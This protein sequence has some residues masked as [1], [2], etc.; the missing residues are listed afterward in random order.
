M[1][2]DQLSN[3][4]RQYDKRTLQAFTC[5]G[6]EPS[7]TDVAVFESDVGF[8]LPGEFREFTM[9]GLGGLYLEVREEFWPRAKL[10]EVGPFWSFL[11]G[12]K[13]FG[14]ARHIPDWL[15]I[16]IQ[17]R[18]FKEGD[19]GELVPFLQLIGSADMYCFDARGQIVQ[20]FHDEPENRE[21]EHLSFSELLMR[22]IH[23]L[24]G[25]RDRK[26]RGE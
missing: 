16:R 25:R 3:Y 18:K 13:V 11:Y 12:L 1:A 5:Q 9:S 26:I 6:N 8:R 15:D 17:Y 21:V 19:F 10:Y 7:A 2:L 14:I 22:E 20:W 4:F 24:E 23:E